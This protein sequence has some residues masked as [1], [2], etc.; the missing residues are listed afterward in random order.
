MTSSKSLLT[1]SQAAKFLGISEDTL[2]RWE[3]QGKFIPERTLGNSRRYDL[4]ALQNIKNYNHKKT[5][6]EALVE[7]K[8]ELK[9]IR[10]ILSNNKQNNNTNSVSKKITKAPEEKKTLEKLRIITN[11]DLKR[12]IISNNTIS[13]IVYQLK[14]KL[15]KLYNYKKIHSS[16]IIGFLIILLFLVIIFIVLNGLTKELKKIG[17]EINSKETYNQEPNISQPK[18]DEILQGKGIIISKDRL[19]VDNNGNI[20]L[21]GA[22]SG[23]YIDATSNNLIVNSGLEQNKSGKALYYLYGEDAGENNAFIS[24][25]TSLDGSNS[26]KIIPT[27]DVV[28]KI[29]PTY[30][31]LSS[32]KTYTLSLY[33]KSLGIVDTNIL[34][35][36]GTTQKN[37]QISGDSSWQLITLTKTFNEKESPTLDNFTIVINANTNGGTL[38]LDNFQL[39]NGTVTTAYK[40]STLETDG[41]LTVSNDIIS[42]ILA[43][44]GSLGTINKP[45]KEFIVN[46]QTI[47][48]DLD[49]YGNTKIEGD[50]T[51]SGSMEFESVSVNN[52]LNISNDG[53]YT[54]SGIGTKRLDNLGNLLNI[55]SLGFN[56]GTLTSSTDYIIS[57][58]GLAI[59]GYSN[60]YF[61]KNGYIKAE[62]I[63]SIQDIKIGDP[64]GESDSLG[65]YFTGVSGQNNEAGVRFNVGS[66]KLEYRDDNTTSWT[67][68]DSL[69]STSSSNDYSA[70]NGLNMDSN[71][72]QLG[73]NLTTDTT[74][75]LGAYD[76]V[77][78]LNS[79]GDIDFQDSGSTILYIGDNGNIGIGTS[80]PT[81]KLDINTYTNF[82]SSLNVASTLTT[83]ALKI[84][85]GAGTDKWLASDALG[86]AIWTDLP[87]STSYL[88]GN[89]LE[90]NGSTF[91]LG[92]SLDFSTSLSTGSYDF[93]FSLDGTGNTN[94]ILS[95]SGDVI[96]KSG[97]TAFA[98]FANNGSFTLDSLIM[99]GNTLSAASAAGLSLMDDG[100]NLGMFIKDEG[101]VGIGTTNPLSKLAVEGVGSFTLGTVDLPGIIFRDDINTGLWSSGADTINFSTNG[102]EMMRINSSGY[103]GIGTTEPTEK[104]A[105]AGGNFLQTAYGNPTLKGS[106]ATADASFG[107]YVSGKYAYLA[108]E[109]AGLRIIDV[110]DPANPIAL[111]SYDSGSN[112]VISV[113]VAGKYAYIGYFENS[114]SIVDVSNPYSP[115]L[116]A[117]VA[118]SGRARDLYV[119][120]KYVYV[121]AGF[122]GLQIVDVSNPSLPVV[123]G[124]YSAGGNYG[125]G[126]YISGN[127]AYLNTYTAANSLYIIN[128]SNPT[129]PTL[130]GTYPG[131]T[132]VLSGN[133]V[134]VSGKYAYIANGATGMTIINVTDPT[135]PTFVS[136]TS[137]GANADAIYVSGNYAYVTDSDGNLSVLNISNPITPTVIGKYDTGNGIAEGVHVAGKYAYVANFAEG[138]KIIDINGMETPA[139]YAG[140]IQTNDITITENGDIGNNL[141]VRNG[142]NVGQGGLYAGGPTSIM[143]GVGITAPHTALTVTQAG[144]GD[145]LNL[146]DNTTEVFTVLDGGNVGIGTTNP[147]SKL[148][149]NGVGSFTLGTVDLP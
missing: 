136:D 23:G 140:N 87:I 58:T 104:L 52:R 130:T 75:T 143:L 84:T 114:M 135:T 14:S 97:D 28:L 103:V 67:T 66:G 92:G 38:Y 131:I 82:S 16:S 17:D 148:E 146:F 46:N 43:D 61:N 2:R 96:F 115:S 30:P 138:L 79:T 24:Q 47:N 73:G 71:D 1:I 81:A 101:N 27:R 127:Y 55:S 134:Y 145:I 129:T 106:I 123:T 41:I 147:Q 63:N 133:N 113:K 70:S 65:I 119:S 50:L 137:I 144:T 118:L 12:N 34:L 94:F 62:Q 33:V 121:A 32:G 124:T 105:L 99:D 83:S 31:E 141:Y 125:S 98:T 21:T 77:Y 132:T 26:L 76:L 22:I 11:Q 8:N 93:N 89:G 48:N 112:N 60:Y 10:E 56:Y 80:S 128:I 42:P 6:D 9:E 3:R 25:D 13:N 64:N 53:L 4:V 109:A 74:T 117:N 90:M 72:I 45:F 20:Q 108:D 40:P 86:N 139:M 107:V 85:Y 54:G 69:T 59:G 88:A 149:I 36:Y 120:G 7:F 78:N 18:D 35:S 29:S 49:V 95:N 37:Y 15:I 19:L 51:V 126:I 91:D 122:A 68:F 116:V 57:S 142:L 100:G 111:G 102:S 39:E 44:T 5:V 110:S